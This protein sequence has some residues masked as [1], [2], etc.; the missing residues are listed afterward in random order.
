MEVAERCVHPV[1]SLHGKRC[2][3][4]L[5]GAHASE[6]AREAKP[7]RLLSLD[8]FRGFALTVMVFVNYGGGGYW[9]FQHAPW[10]GLTVA[11]L[12]M[13]WFVFIIGTSVVLAFSSMQKRGVNCLQLLRKITWRTVVL[14][15]L[16]FCFLNYSPRDGPYFLGPDTNPRE[17]ASLEER[18]PRYFLLL[19][20]V[21]DYR[22]AGDFMAVHHFPHA[23]TQLPH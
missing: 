15:M 2:S 13:P 12:V 7:S 11:D 20:S 23:C 5:E 9:F 18:C 10:N 17:S 3:V 14:M 21:G 16:G 8:A 6:T 1:V 22:A 4:F 19:A